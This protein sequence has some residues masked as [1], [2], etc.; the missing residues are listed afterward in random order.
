MYLDLIV[1]ILALINIGVSGF[2][3][4]NLHKTK[5]SRMKPL[6]KSLT[7]YAVVSTILIGAFYLLTSPTPSLLGVGAGMLYLL[8]GSFVFT[9]EV[10]GYL[11][12]KRHEGKRQSI[13]KIG[14][15]RW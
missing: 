6:W 12:L 14:E 1:S 8:I 11:Y 5:S 9:I 7:A 3:V 10:P 13:W 15:A 4:Y 2:L